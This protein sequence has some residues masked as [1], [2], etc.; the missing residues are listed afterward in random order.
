MATY[1][2][3]YA[4]E[5]N[6]TTRENN[7]Q[8]EFNNKVALEK[9][10]SDVNDLKDTDRTNELIQG[11]LTT[12][13]EGNT[14]K[15]I[16]DTYKAL[17]SGEKTLGEAMG[18][19]G[20]V[21]DGIRS[22]SNKVKGVKGPAPPP[23]AD[24]AQGVDA[25]GATEESVQI[26][27]NDTPAL[28]A[29]DETPDPTAEPPPVESAQIAESDTP[30]LPA[31][32]ETPALDAEA[33]PVPGAGAEVGEGEKALG[34]LKN[35]ASVIEEVGDSGLV[36]TIGKGALSAGGKLLGNVG[37][38]IDVVKD[39]E[40]VKEGGISKIFA[41]SGTSGMDEAGNAMQ[42]V[43]GLM[44]V[45]GVGAPLGALLSGIGGILGEIGSHED[46]KEKEKHKSD[47]PPASTPL[48]AS[49]NVGAIGGIA[50]AQINPMHMITGSGTF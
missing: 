27:D 42:V 47:A 28:P 32:D 15:K 29:I 6:D 7:A 19:Q 21:I 39:I 25:G 9:H 2:A 12:M 41:G 44:D 36:S 24:P 38:A 20:A 1:G 49:A 3:D 5:L 40:A 35:G 46:D 48:T 17:K 34:A 10:T 11:G 33:P 31:I 50:S 30:A 22:L 13:V 43:G 8:V 14:V 4:R 26:A 16:S 18:S 45:T 23:N 37:G